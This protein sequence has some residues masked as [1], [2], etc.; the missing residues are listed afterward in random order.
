MSAASWHYSTQCAPYLIRRQDRDL[1]LHFAI[2]RQLNFYPVWLKLRY[3][4]S[5]RQEL[6][7]RIAGCEGVVSTGRHPL[8]EK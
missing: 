8:K 4:V 1:N 5:V 3:E 6:S 7:V 2:R